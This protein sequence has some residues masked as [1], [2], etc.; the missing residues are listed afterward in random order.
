MCFDV[1]NFITAI[2]SERESLTSSHKTVLTKKVEKKDEIK[3][4]HKTADASP[5][6]DGISLV[7]VVFSSIT[8]KF[9]GLRHMV[10]SSLFFPI[11]AG[12]DIHNNTVI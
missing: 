6:R 10:K 7:S 4:F 12:S 5:L 2:L 9:L 1:F 8:K 3:A 11:T